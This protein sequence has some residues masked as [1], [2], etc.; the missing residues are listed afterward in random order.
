[1][2]QELALQKKL[3]VPHIKKPEYTTTVISICCFIF[4][5]I[6]FVRNYG[7]KKSTDLIQSIKKRSITPY[8]KIP[9]IM[10]L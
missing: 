10:P 5:V 3:L 6:L 2:E 1:M 9:T 7:N 4:L 8:T